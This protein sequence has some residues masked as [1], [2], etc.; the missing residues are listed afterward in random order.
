[1]SKD[2]A[3]PEICTSFPLRWSSGVVQLHRHVDINLNILFVVKKIII[4]GTQKTKQTN[5]KPLKLWWR[6]STV[7]LV[8]NTITLTVVIWENVFPNKFCSRHFDF[9]MEPFK[10]MY[11]HMSHLKLLTYSPALSPPEFSN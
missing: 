8:V 11:N 4:I 1:M 5:K 9:L 2:S 3:V 10:M 7:F 6:K